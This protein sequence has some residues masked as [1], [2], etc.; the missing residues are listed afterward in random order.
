M[1]ARREPFSS[2]GNQGPHALEECHLMSHR[3]TLRIRG[4]AGRTLV[5][6]CC[7]TLMGFVASPAP[8]HAQGPATLRALGEYRLTM[9]TLRKIITAGRGINAGPDAQA[10]NA[11]TNRPAMSI[12]D[13]MGV[14]DRYPAAKRAVASSGLSPREFAT[15]SRVGVHGA[16]PGGCRGAKGTGADRRRA[17]GAREAGQRDAPPR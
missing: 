8:A 5:A 16:L 9:P 17:A 11:A 13:L 14:F 3:Y 2:D 7:L 15:A 4:L 6:A 10:I 12:E 1:G